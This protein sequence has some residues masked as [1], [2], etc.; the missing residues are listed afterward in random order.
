MCSGRRVG[1]ASWLGQQVNAQHHN[2]AR[3]C[4]AALT[5]SGFHSAAR[6]RMW[7]GCQVSRDAAT[8][9]ACNT[10]WH[11]TARMRWHEASPHVCCGGMHAAWDAGSAVRT[12]S[13]H[14]RLITCMHGVRGDCMHPQWQSASRQLST[15]RCTAVGINEKKLFITLHASHMKARTTTRQK[16]VFHTLQRQYQ[17]SSTTGAETCFVWI[18]AVGAFPL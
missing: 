2:T 3:R 10:K 18:P 14:L 5:V 7:G 16:V 8:T 6:R 15:N 1:A 13:C 17:I 12:D 9:A 11:S 4:K